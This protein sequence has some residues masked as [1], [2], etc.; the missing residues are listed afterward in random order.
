MA[1]QFQLYDRFEVTKSALFKFCI[2]SKNS[3]LLRFEHESVIKNVGR[4]D[5]STVATIS[6]LNLFQQAGIILTELTNL[7]ELLSAIHCFTFLLKEEL[8]N[9]PEFNE[10][11]STFCMEMFIC[12]YKLKLRGSVVYKEYTVCL[13]HMSLCNIIHI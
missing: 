9:T 3:L 5:C 4:P 11:P 6:D 12:S 2:I 7:K 8:L 10:A 1:H 13:L